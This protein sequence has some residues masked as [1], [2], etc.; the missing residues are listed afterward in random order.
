[1]PAELKAEL[2]VETVIDALGNVQA[3]YCSIIWLKSDIEAKS[4]V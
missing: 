4:V 3:Y 1:M 2:K